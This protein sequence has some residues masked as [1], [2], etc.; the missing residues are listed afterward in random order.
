[1]ASFNNIFFNFRDKAFRFS[2]SAT[3]LI[4]IVI[5]IG[6][7]CT[8]LS[9]S[10]PSIKALGWKFIYSSSWDPVSDDYGALPFLVGTLLT[11]LLALLIA[12]PFSLAIGLFLG[13]YYTEGRISSIFKN[14]IEL[15][16]AIPSVIYGF[17]GL[18]VLVP[19]IRSIETMI[20]VVPYG[21]GLFTA[22][23][24]LAIMIMPYA[25]SL[26]RQVISMTPVHLKEAAYSLGATR[27]EVIQKVILPYSR[28]GIFAGI[29]LALG[30]ALGETMAVTM[31]I[32]NNHAIPKSIFG[33]ANTMPSVI[34]NEFSEA[35]GT[36][37][38]SALIEMALL[39]FV[40]TTLVN[41]IGVQIIKQFTYDDK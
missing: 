36:L 16:A 19:I 10:L 28:S 33:P 9:A 5:L 18:F 11:S 23:F 7:F 6:I 39:L 37:Y 29:L 41:F 3:S 13:E 30:R 14:V 27:Y 40:V 31:L 22:S 21:I 26:T 17:W 24:I 38:T 12:L 8:L 25:V 15:L 35:T 34:A 4:L 2:L 1:M 20:G 32:G